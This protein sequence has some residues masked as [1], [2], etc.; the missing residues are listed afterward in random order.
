MKIIAVIQA[1]LASTRLEHK[2]LVDICG[3][4]MIQHVIERARAIPGVTTVVATVPSKDQP[5]LD[6]LADLDV[7]IYFHEPPNVLLGYHRAAQHE[8]ADAVVRLTGDCPLLCPEASEAVLQRFLAERCDYA[9]NTQWHGPGVDGLDTECIS[10]YAL[11]LAQAQVGN[12]ED[13]EH[14]TPWIRRNFRCVHVPFGIECR[15]TKISVDTQEDLERV[16]RI[17]ARIPGDYSWAATRRAIEE[18][19]A[20]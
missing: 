20:P 8:G 6:V 13:R 10:R 15:D 7:E 16:R 14:V 3:R 11:D 17:M 5:L 4:P 19:I 2:A 12:A 1:R 9:S 18:E